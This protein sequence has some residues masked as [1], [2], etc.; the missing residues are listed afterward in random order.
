VAQALGVRRFVYLSG[1]GAGQNRSEPWFR[2]K[3]QA[4]AAIRESEKP[5]KK[6]IHQKHRRLL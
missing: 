1:A 6:N 4:E 2:A 5:D 3:D